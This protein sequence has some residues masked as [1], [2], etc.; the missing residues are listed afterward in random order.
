MDRERSAV[1]LAALVDGEGAM[2]S[3]AII[4]ENTDSDIIEFARKCL[5]VLSISYSIRQY[6]IKSGKTVW[7]IQITKR[8]H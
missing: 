2:G 1:Y 3:H 5:D 4:I 8:K 6:K 7:H